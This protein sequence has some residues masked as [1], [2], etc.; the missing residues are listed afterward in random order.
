MNDILILASVVLLAALFLK[1]PVYIA[2]L[3]GSMVYFVLNPDINP[4][5]FAQRT[6]TGTENISLLAIPFFIC[7]GILMNY[8]G[9]TARIMDLCGALTGRMPGGLAQVNVLLSTLMGGLSGSNLADAA[10]EA[11]MLV[12]V[13]EAKGYTKSFSSAVTAASAIITPIIPPGIA[14]ILYGCI[15]DVSIG[16]LFTSGLGVGILLTSSMMVLVHI[17]S[18]RAGYKPIRT[19]VLPAGELGRS[20]RA[21]ILPLLLPLV[22]IGGIRA[23]VFTATEAGTVA[24]VYALSLGLAFKEMKLKHIVASCKETVV[25]S[26]SIMLII[27]AA[28]VFSWVLTRERVPQAMAEWMIKTIDNKYV[29]LAAINIVLLFVGMFIEGNASMIVLVPLLHPIAVAYGIDP[30]QFAMVFILNSAI[31]CITPPMGTLMFVTCGI[32]HCKTKDFIRDALPYYVL[33]L[34]VLALI[35]FVPFFTT[36]LV[37]IVY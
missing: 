10:M 1:A 13:M 17:L 19:E 3:A 34:A 36:G 30:I 27:A 16:K 11:K 2:I 20:L 6:I 4:I 22:I 28:S 7:G 23:G 24:C 26:S 32:T 5:I 37:H 14:M 18:V 21:A 29:F 12:P 31:G 35:T 15:A 9:V 8:S 33:F 25:S